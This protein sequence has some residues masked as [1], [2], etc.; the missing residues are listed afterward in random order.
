VSPDVPECIIIA[1]GGL[2]YMYTAMGIPFFVI[3]P[4]Y[5]NLLYKMLFFL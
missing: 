2:G 4:G 1:Q 3:S 5:I